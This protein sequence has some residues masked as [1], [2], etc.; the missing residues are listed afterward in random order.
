MLHLYYIVLKQ[1]IPNTFR[2][3]HVDTDSVLCGLEISNME[4]L[5]IV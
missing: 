3:T 2:F 1:Y 5:Q 4:C